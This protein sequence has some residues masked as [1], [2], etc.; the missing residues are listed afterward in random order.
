VEENA[1]NERPEADKKAKDGKRKERLKREAEEEEEGRRPLLLQEAEEMKAA[2]KKKEYF[3]R[4]LAED[5]RSV[6]PGDATRAK[7]VADD[8]RFGPPPDGFVWSVLF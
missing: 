4:V 3:V 6:A 1:Q 7:D 8:G 2:R 5:A